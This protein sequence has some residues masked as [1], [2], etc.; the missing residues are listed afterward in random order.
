M[1]LSNQLLWALNDHAKMRET[2]PH[3]PR[4]ADLMLETDL[5]QLEL[6]RTS[7]DK[8]DRPVPIRVR[9]NKQTGAIEV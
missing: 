5:A 9:I 8:F 1:F 6:N 4:M 7:Q 3:A 2:K